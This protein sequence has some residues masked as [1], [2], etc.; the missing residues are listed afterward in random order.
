[1]RKNVTVK[2]LMKHTGEIQPLS[3]FWDNGEEIVIDKVLDSRP[4][5]SLKGGGMGIRYH[6]RIGSKERFI[7]LDGFVWFVEIDENRN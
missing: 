5:A 3:I 2:A 4:R 7:F 1:M 6:V